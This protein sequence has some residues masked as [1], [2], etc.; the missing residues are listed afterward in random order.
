MLIVD[1]SAAVRRILGSIFIDEGFRVDTAADG[2]V[3]QDMLG[4]NEYDVVLVDLSMPFMSGIELYQR[5]EGGHP[6][7][8]T[9]VV[10]MS[11]DMPD[12]RTRSFFTKINRPFL[13]KP[14]TTGD[15]MNALGNYGV[16][17]LVLG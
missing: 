13:L 4:K 12:P 9:K 14:S 7:G 11:V 2:I 6:E 8:A 3:A 1:D 16:G 5:I 10:F 17:N 15:L